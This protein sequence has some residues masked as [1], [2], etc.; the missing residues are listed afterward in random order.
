MQMQ[1]AI[2]AAVSEKFTHGN[3]WTGNT[4]VLHWFNFNTGK[5][6]DFNVSRADGNV[7]IQELNEDRTVSERLRYSFATMATFGTQPAPG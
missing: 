3:M 4:F 1:I 5:Q 2:S 6:V 7:R